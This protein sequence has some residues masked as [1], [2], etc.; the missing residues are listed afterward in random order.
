MYKELI[1]NVEVISTS[2]WGKHL[3]HR[4]LGRHSM[5]NIGRLNVNTTKLISISILH[6]MTETRW[7]PHQ[8]INDFHFH[9]DNFVHGERPWNLVLV[10]IFNKLL[11][12]YL[13]K[14][15]LVNMAADELTGHNMSKYS[16]NRAQTAM[17]NKCLGLHSHIHSTEKQLL[18]VL[19][20][21]AILP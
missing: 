11:N 7:N 17:K 21:F 19:L 3:V 10:W 5:C 2:V 12:V 16:R 15:H 8:R 20:H 9:V 18:F 1:H 14:I 6:M 13:P 4:N